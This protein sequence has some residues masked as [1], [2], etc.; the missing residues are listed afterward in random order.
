MA[1]KQPQIQLWT[2]AEYLE[3]E[4]KAQVRH[5][6]CRGEIY[7]MAGAR[8]NHVRAVGNLNIEIGSQLKGQPCESMSN[9]M[10][11]RIPDSTSYF[12]PDLLVVCEPQWEDDT[13]DTLLNPVVLVEVLSDSTAQFDRVSKWNLYRQ[14]PSLRHYILVAPHRVEV[15]HR[16]RLGE[17]QWSIEI[18]ESL[19]DE[20]I[21]ASIDCRVALRDIYARIELQTASPH[22]PSAI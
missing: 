14:I 2:A 1:Q 22:P 4:R 21:L 15:E 10:R 5:E 16:S 3:F 6:L 9:D 12:Y 20:L 17:N 8:R 13:F 18:L 7:A 11:V 19:D